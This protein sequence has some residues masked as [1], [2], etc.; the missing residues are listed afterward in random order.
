MDTQL[1]RTSTGRSILQQSGGVFQAGHGSTVQINGGQFVQ[2]NQTQVPHNCHEADDG[3]KHLQA[4]VATTAFDSGQHVD[5]PKCH[6]NTRQ[7]V[8]DEIMNWII[9]AVA[10]VQ[11][12]LWLNGAAGAGK[13]AIGRSI[14]E[15]CLQRNIPIARFFFYRTDSTRNNVKPLVAT[16]VHQLLQSIPD[17]TPIIIPRIQLDS[18]I[19][20]KSLE[21]Q[22][23]YLIFDPLRELKRQSKFLRTLVLFFDGVD[24][25]DDHTDQYGGPIMEVF[26]VNSKLRVKV[27]N[28]MKCPPNEL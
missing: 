23:N 13:S 21:T 5:A 10:R 27:F 15:L 2:H 25:C 20:T 4:H 17:L 7:A 6:P 16:L 12:V 11:W 1:L 28:A 3:L 9:L 8:L 18:L 24:E 26:R 19:F 14:V 22:L